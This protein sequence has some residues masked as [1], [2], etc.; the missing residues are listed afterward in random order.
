MELCVAEEAKLRRKWI[1]EK[2][3]K[4]LST[5]LKENPKRS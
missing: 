4:K 2:E 3:E 1:D 5:K